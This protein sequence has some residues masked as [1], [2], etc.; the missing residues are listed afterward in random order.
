MPDV[1]DV[2]VLEVDV[3]PF[4]VTTSASFTV[5]HPDGSSEV[6]AATP[7][8]VEADVDGETV[9]VQRWTSGNLTYDAPRQ[10]VIIAAVTGTGVSVQPR[11]VWV[12]ALPT[13][14]G[15]AWRPNL[16]RVATYIPERTV[17]VD[18]L[19]DGKPVLTFTD[20][21]RPT[22]VQVA[23]QIDDA[24]AWV[25]TACGDLDTTLYDTARGLAAIRA[26]GMA[27]ASWPVRDGDLSAAQI[28][29]QQ[30]D[31]GLKALAAR[32]ESLTGVDPDDPDGVFEIAPP[33][34]CTSSWGDQLL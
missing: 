31:S 34:S 27:E 28:L 11:T 3:H 10:W 25:A 19:S 22:A 26:A 14:G 15:V 9:T 20:D 4:D 2:E 33:Y 6:L 18:R 24:V 32:N 1:G 30:A 8:E 17:A 5:V 12:D 21:T 16:E 13:G 29:L 23:Q 7:T